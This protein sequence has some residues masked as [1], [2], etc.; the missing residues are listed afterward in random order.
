MGRILFFMDEKKY[1]NSSAI[2]LQTLKKNEQTVSL[3]TTKKCSNNEKDI[4]QISGAMQPLSDVP[5]SNDGNVP[6]KTEQ[7]PEIKPQTVVEVGKENNTTQTQKTETW[8]HK[9]TSGLQSIGFSKIF[10]SK[11]NKIAIGLVVLAVLLVLMLNINNTSGI[12]K[13]TSASTTFNAL[14]YVSSKKYVE[15]LEVKLVQVLSQIKG[16]GNVSVMITLESGPELKIA[17]SV[18]ERKNTT[19]SNSTTTTSVTVVENPIII[20]QNGQSSPLVLM[21]IMPVIKGVVVVAEGANNTRT[22][23]ELLEAVQALLK[24]SNQNIQ[25]YAGI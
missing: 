19:T 18:D 6:F 16:A 3:Q 8:Y 14:E 13:T 20:T 22:K 7:I 15:N 17:T 11:N 10:A 21:E 25:I 1:D 23:L 2:V 12:S 24:I 4:G 5:N 9:L